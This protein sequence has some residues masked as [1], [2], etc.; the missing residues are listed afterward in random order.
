MHMNRLP[1]SDTLCVCLKVINFICVI[2]LE[3]FL[4]ITN[5]FTSELLAL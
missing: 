5:I 1:V 2:H 3:Y 4:C